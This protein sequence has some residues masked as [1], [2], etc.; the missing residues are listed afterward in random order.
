[1]LLEL[2]G[3]IAIFLVL[4][5]AYA[6]IGERKKPVGVFASILLLLYGVL[7]LIGN[8]EYT[9]GQNEIKTVDTTNPTLSVTNS[10]IVPTTVQATL[11]SP[12]FPTWVTYGALLGVSCLLLS[13]WGLIHYADEFVF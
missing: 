10:T 1:M 4:L 3:V 2:Y 11:P 13:M 7:F 8:V 9:Y 12:P 6:E 5:F